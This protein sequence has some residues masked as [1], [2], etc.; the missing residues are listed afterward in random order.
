MASDLGH[1]RY[2]N[3]IRAENTPTIQDYVALS[4]Q[5]HS[6]LSAMQSTVNALSSKNIDASTMNWNDYQTTLISEPNWPAGM[7]AC[8]G[9]MS[10]SMSANIASPPALADLNA[11]VQQCFT[12]PAA[13]QTALGIPIICAVGTNADGSTKHHITLDWWPNAASPSIL[14]LTIF[15]PP[16]SND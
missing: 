8:W 11:A 4:N 5:W 6:P 14:Y 7:F 1:K 9:D 12:Q 2:L 15:C 13:G 16:T 10:N 3:P